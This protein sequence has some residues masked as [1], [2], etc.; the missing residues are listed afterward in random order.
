[1]SRVA[2]KKGDFFFF[3]LQCGFLPVVCLFFEREV[4]DQCPAMW[5]ETDR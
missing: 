2:R 4:G 1:M 3:F 5:T